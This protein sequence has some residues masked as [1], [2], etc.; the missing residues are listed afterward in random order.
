MLNLC[1]KL[2]NGS[3]DIKHQKS[4]KLK[5]SKI[6]EIWWN[7]KEN[8]WLTDKSE[9]WQSDSKTKGQLFRMKLE[10]VGNCSKIETEKSMIINNVFKRWR[11]KS[12]NSETMNRFWPKVKIK[13]QC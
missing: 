8:L 13:L 1:K 2:K 6:L 4:Q 7:V 10:K 11:F 3:L 5:S 9:K 12:C